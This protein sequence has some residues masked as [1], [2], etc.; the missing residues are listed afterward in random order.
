M[1]DEGNLVAL[2]QEVD[3]GK[4]SRAGFLNPLP[5]KQYGYGLAQWTSPKRKEKLYNLA[6]SKGKSIG[7]ENIQLEYLINELRISYSKVWKTLQNAKSVREA[8]DIVLKQFEMP[9]DVS[10]SVCRLRESYGLKYLNAQEGNEMNDAIKKLIGVAI[11]EIGYL[12]KAS[13][14]DLYNKV[15]NAGDRNYTKYGKEL[16]KLRPDIIDYPAYWCDQFVDWC[17]VKAFGYDTAIKMLCGRVDD[18]TVASAALYKAAGRWYKEPQAGDQVFFQS[19]RINHTGIVIEVRGDEIVTVEGNTSGGSGIVRNGGGV[20]KK[21]YKIGNPRIAGYG[22]PNYAVAPVQHKYEKGWH[23]SDKGWWYADTEDTYTANR[24]ALID[25]RW[26]VFDAAGYMITGWFQAADGWYYLNPDDGAM[27]SGQ[28]L[29]LDDKTYYLTKSGVMAKN[30]YVKGE[31]G[32]YHLVDWNGWWC[33]DLDTTKPDF[34]KFDV[35]E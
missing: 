27:L 26:Y 18:Y 31:N 24:W 3:S 30:A 35:A 22:R 10:E 11:N 15:A 7:D 28:W 1:G 21:V 33:R 23:K 19:N 20:F 25:G 17:F 29:E 8:S 9:E 34:K 32:V 16:N 4:I 12:E 2:F 5:N 14:K 6:R 13:D